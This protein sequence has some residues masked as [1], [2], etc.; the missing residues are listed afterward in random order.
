MSEVRNGDHKVYKYLFSEICF[1]FLEEALSTIVCIRGVQILYERV[2][3]SIVF[4][5][6]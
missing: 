3:K 1:V 6:V 2:F 4:M 5:G